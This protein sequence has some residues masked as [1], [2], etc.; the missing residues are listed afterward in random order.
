[1]CGSLD[2]N[3]TAYQIKRYVFKLLEALSV[4]IAP[5]LLQL[6][7]VVVRS[8]REGYF[9]VVFY[10]LLLSAFSTSMPQSELKLLQSRVQKPMSRLS[11]GKVIE[12]PSIIYGYTTSNL[13]ILVSAHQQHQQKKQAAITW[14]DASTNRGEHR[15]R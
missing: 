10:L 7:K 2:G 4:M 12:R 11:H 8:R 9:T 1:M 5:R 15:V 14:Q 13:L 3:L 6:S